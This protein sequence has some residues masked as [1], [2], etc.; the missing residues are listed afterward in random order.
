M[1]G[2]EGELFWGEPLWGGELTFPLPSVGKLR[3]GYKQGPGLGF[4]AGAWLSLGF[5]PA[6]ALPAR[7]LHSAAT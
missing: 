1:G 5:C 2:L 7:C 4:A 6:C 3:Q